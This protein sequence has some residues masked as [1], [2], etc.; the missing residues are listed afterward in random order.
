MMSTK[1]SDFLT[2]PCPHLDL[3]CTIK[4]AQL[5]L[6]RLLFQDP[7]PPFLLWKSYLEAPLRDAV[8]CTLQEMRHLTVLPSAT[9]WI[10][11]GLAVCRTIRVTVFI[12]WSGERGWQAGSLA[13]AAWANLPSHSSSTHTHSL[14][15]LKFAMF[16]TSPMAA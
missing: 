4:F 12:V 7:T 15:S 14:T 11:G 5:P 6:L 13:R 1:F 10:N 16:I 9:H 2:P 3:I 8:V